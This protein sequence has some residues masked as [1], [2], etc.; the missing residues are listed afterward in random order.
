MH[1]EV[2]QKYPLVDAIAVESR[3]RALGAREGDVLTQVDQYFNHPAR[4]FG[5]TDEALRLRQVGELNYITY[6]G[7]KLDRNSK[8]RR[9]LELPLPGGA[10]SKDSFAEMLLALGFR[11]VAEVRKLR[12]IFHLRWQD[13]EVEIALDQVESLG[14]FLEIELTA[15]EATLDA[16]KLCLESLANELQLPANERRSYL[17]LLL[18]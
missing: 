16:A 10:S 6:K 4:D 1:F 13:R 5:K 15:N 12:R 2:E 7:P 11:P 8:T 9:E 14:T 18:R 3:L 17:E